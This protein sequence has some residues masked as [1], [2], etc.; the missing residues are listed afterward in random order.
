MR[1]IL[2]LLLALAF[3]AIASAEVYTSFTWTPYRQRTSGGAVTITQAANAWQASGGN[4]SQS[5]TGIGSYIEDFVQSSETFAVEGI[6][7]EFDLSGTV[8]TSL[9]YVGPFVLLTEGSGKGWN[10]GQAI[11][12]QT[13]YRWEYS[14]TAGAVAR[15]GRIG[16]YDMGRVAFSGINGG[17]AAHHVITVQRG[18]YTWAV[19]GVT[20][21]SA[22]MGSAPYTNMRLI[23]GARIYDQGRPQSASITNLKVTTAT[24]AYTGPGNVT[25]TGTIADSSG[26][27]TAATC[28]GNIKH[29][30]SGATVTI[31]GAVGCTGSSTVYVNVAG[32]YD[33]ASRA[34]TG[35]YTDAV[36]GTTQPLSFV[37]TGGDLQWQARIT[38]TAAGSTGGRAFDLTVK[39]TLPADAYRASSDLSDLRFS[40]TISQSQ[41]ITVPLNIPEIGVNV[42][43]PLN[44]AVTGTWEVQVVPGT[45][46]A[47]TLS[48]QSSGTFAGDRP[49]TA[50]G[51]VVVQGRTISVPISFNVTGSFGGT[52]SGSSAGNNLKFVGNWTS[53]GGDQSFGGSISLTLPIDTST[54]RIPNMAA[55]FQGAMS[56]QIS[57]VTPPSVPVSF[58]SSA[59][60]VVTPR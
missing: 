55:A 42:N 37:A 31:T 16:N 14:G 57:N 50:T 27:P 25:A 30:G 23:V 48:G 6:R 41:A 19:N 51:S 59:P 44:V 7:V 11:G 43:F 46:G 34:F 4:L 38:G 28:T 40:G 54:G 52:L 39:F 56:P 18:V 45:A 53:T 2:A 9:G 29:N 32:T 3:P 47:W 22:D 49:V 20:M 24:P 15:R 12:A 17:T 58:S 1:S 10:Y 26:R 35:T 13:F 21:A 8:G 5:L 60:L 36:G 33:V